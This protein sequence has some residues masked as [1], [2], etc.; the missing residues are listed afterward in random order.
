[1]KRIIIALS[2]LTLGVST[3]KA[4]WLHDDAEKQRIIELQRQFDEQKHASGSWEGVAFVLG[5][6]CMVTLITGTII[7]SRAR[8]HAKEASK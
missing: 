7:G 5:L 1:M 6:G 4:S 3:L 2:V 8:R